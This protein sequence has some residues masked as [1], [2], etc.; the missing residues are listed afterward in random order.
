MQEKQSTTY[1]CSYC[2]RYY[3]QK[4]HA[5]KHEKGCRD[6]PNNKHKCF[7]MCK[8]LNRETIS[9]NNYENRRTIFTCQLTKQRMYS[10]LAEKKGLLKYFR[11]SFEEDEAIRMPLVCEK[12]EMMTIDTMEADFNT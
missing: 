2:R 4:H 7:E 6:N 9:D 5:A 3:L 8:H 1:H 12:Y 11:E 10:Y